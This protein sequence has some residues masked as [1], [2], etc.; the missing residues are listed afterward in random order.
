M[1]AWF[2]KLVVLMLS[3]GVTMSLA[4]AEDEVQRRAAGVPLRGTITA[5]NTNEI[6]IQRKDN[7]KSETVSVHEVAKVKY[8]GG[9][10]AA[11]FTQAESLEKGGEYQKA[12]DAYAKIAQENS[13]N[14]FLVRAAHFGRVSSLV[15]QSQRDTAKLDDAIAALEE[16]KKQHPDS[17]FHYT[18]HE[19]L[20]QLYLAKGNAEAASAALAE[21]SKAPWPD[22]K[23][24]AINYAGRIL[25][26]GDQP[27][28]A[29][30][31]FDSVINSAGDTPEVATRRHEALLG[32]AECLIKQK[33]NEDAEKILRE[34]IG[35]VSHD[36]S[37][38]RAPVHNFLGDILRESSRTE[39]AI[40]NYLY[41]DIYYSRERDEHAKALCYITLLFEQRGQN[42]RAED[43]R[44]R[45]KKD[46]PA[47]P[48]VKVAEGGGTQ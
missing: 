42:D 18:L 22:L 4:L 19:M 11:E 40:R 10:A 5:E 32:K 8:E 37:T 9:K 34:L 2:R 33:K 44:S 46:Y 6:T 48:W 27:D 29:I 20:G 7:G 17:R 25:L 43:M 16:F 45:L 28:A 38:I 13:G 30:S 24:K 39:E 1:L 41:V 21:L 15:R 47:S 14:T 12:I 26:I 3:F 31:Q 35:S 23:L 36:E